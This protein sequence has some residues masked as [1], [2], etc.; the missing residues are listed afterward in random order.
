M[1]TMSSGKTAK[2][3][4]FMELGK[5]ICSNATSLFI[6]YSPKYQNPATVLSGRPYSFLQVDGKEE[7]A[8]CGSY[9]N[10][11]EAHRVVDLIHN[12]HTASSS[13]GS[14]SENNNNNNNKWH[15]VD[16][17]R[18]ITFYRAQVILVQQLLSRR[19]LPR[20][21]VATVDSSQGCEADLVIVSFV[22]S[23][24]GYHQSNF[25]AGFLTDDRRM[26]VALSKYKCSACSFVK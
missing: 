9:R 14:S 8:V 3:S 2:E 19:G 17:V 6:L 18:I 13:L 21:L 23:N 26:N 15:G 12:L 7:Q 1:E 16:R 4:D 5:W 11:A 10:L 22:R 25:A 20:I 24:S